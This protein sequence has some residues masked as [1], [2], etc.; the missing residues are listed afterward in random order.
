MIHDRLPAKF[1]SPLTLRRVRWSALLAASFFSLTWVLRAE[2]L[3]KPAPPVVQAPS[4]G[5]NEA[6]LSDDLTDTVNSEDDESSGIQPVSLTQPQPAEL[7]PL[8]A[9]P[10]APV[11]PR[12]AES[13][14]TLFD[15]RRLSGEV[16]KEQRQRRAARASS[17]VVIGLEGKAR[18]TTDSGSL[19]SKSPSSVGLG[20]QRRTPIVTDPRIHSTRVGSQNA[21]GS[22]WFPARIDLDTHLNKLDSRIIDDIIVTK[23]PYSALYGPDFHFYDV[24]LLSS[25]RYDDLESHGCTSLEYRSNGEQWYGR[26]TGMVGDETWGA[27]LG[28]G[29]RTG[30]DYESGDGTGIPSS[31]KSRDVDLALGFDLGTDDQIEFHLLRLDQTDVEF[32]GQAFDMDYLVTDGYELSWF[33]QGGEFFDQIEFDTW[34]NQTRFEGNTFR[35]GKSRQFSVFADPVVNL[36]ATTDVEAASAGY[37]LLFHRDTE[38]FGRWTV[39]TDLRF[40]RQELE[41]LASGDFTSLGG[42]LLTDRNSPIPQS[43]WAN[44]GLL[45][46]NHQQVNERLG[47]HSGARVDFVSTGIDQSLASLGDLG[48]A[49]VPAQLSDILGSDEFGQEFAL[50]SVFFNGSYELTE[51][52]TLNAG[53]G[54]AERAPNLTELYVAEAF[55]FLLQNGL[56]TVTGDPLLKKETLWQVDVGVSGEWDRVRGSANFFH[57]WIEDYITFE[58]MGQSLL[59][60]GG[61]IATRLKY[62]NTDLATLTGCDFVLEADLNPSLTA[63]GSLSYI[64]GEDRTRNGHFATIPFDGSG[65][66]V[67]P[68]VRNPTEIRGG[69]PDGQEGNAQEPLPAI[70]PL[71]TRIGLRWHQRK[72][73]PDWAVELA[74][75]IVDAQDRV[76]V[77]LNE[78]PT[79]GFT[80]WDLRGYWRPN[81]HWLLTTGVE[82]FT[83]KNYFEHLDYRSGN[84][85]AVFQPGTNFYFGTEWSY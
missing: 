53:A 33:H 35:S 3:Q 24:E 83:N 65:P 81:R 76:A 25:P 23:G 80:T 20:V 73:R 17:N 47:I 36:R 28:Y 56:N 40:L 74:A 63:F 6:N 42:T 62:V 51:H 8:R 71:E 52:L 37:R 18:S 14:A 77:S 27:R 41:E 48:G 43:H 16:L 15:S 70:V 9:A 31:F 34:Y 19:I 82:N 32:P 68:S 1:A 12:R 21:S 61:D 39:G 30:S 26:Q 57:S 78:R 11:P 2:E 4:L 66:G 50:A 7:P 55:L 84:G 60:S 5:H 49:V 45:I 79:P 54:R 38:E 85:F 59:S 44:P 22:Y 72:S 69:A 58:N 29:H 10:V 64:E 67:T 75:R 46:E 13:S